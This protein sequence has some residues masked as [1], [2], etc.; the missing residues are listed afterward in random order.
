VLSE[1]LAAEADLGQVLTRADAFAAR[2]PALQAAT[3][4]LAVFEPSAGSLRYA[5]CGILPRWWSGRRAGQ[6]P[7]RYRHRPAGHGLIPRPGPRRAGPG[8]LLLLYSDGLIER[9]N[10]TIEE[11]MAELAKVAA[12]AAA[13]RTLSVA[14]DPLDPLDPL[15]PVAPVDVSTPSA[16]E[17]VCQLTW[18]CSPA[19]DTPMTSPPWRRSGWPNPSRPC[20]WN[21]QANEPA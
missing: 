15:A 21:C 7:D 9:P 16:A 18:N 14:A 4:T 2:N 13:N 20:G 8:E 10:K 17:R 3:L 6:V 11:G 1:L 12:D 5:T 19:R